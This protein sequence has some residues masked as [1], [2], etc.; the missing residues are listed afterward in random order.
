LDHQLDRRAKP[1][2]EFQEACAPK[3]ILLIILAHLLGENAHGPEFPSSVPHIHTFL[4]L[5]RFASAFQ[6]LFGAPAW[7]SFAIHAIDIAVC[8]RSSSASS[9][10]SASPLLR[11]LNT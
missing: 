3:A 8:F 9:I 7:S 2:V 1:R 5:A 11:A 10:F 4:L 6:T